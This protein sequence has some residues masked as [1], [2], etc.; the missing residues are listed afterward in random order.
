MK[1][2]LFVFSTALLFLAL[3]A[4]D[5]KKTTTEPT[6][7]APVPPSITFSSPGTQDTCSI[8]ANGIVSFANSNTT[9]LAIFAQIPPINNGNDYT[10]SLPADSLTVNVKA[11]RQSDGS[12]T[13]EI[14]F[15]GVEDGVSFSNKLILGGTT[16]ADGKNGNMTAYSET[17]AAV[18]GTFSWTTSASNVITGTFIE[19]DE[20]EADTYK[21][22]LIS[23]PSGS[24]EVTTFVWVG[25]AWVQEFHATWAAQGGPATC[26]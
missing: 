18:I 10:W 3:T 8:Q 17:S 11:T 14:R 7:S 23:N 21:I 4:G 24:G 1:K 2:T 15:N 19:K 9:I 5:C 16:S 25:S 22:V 6:G 12:F 13:W 26:G 20:T